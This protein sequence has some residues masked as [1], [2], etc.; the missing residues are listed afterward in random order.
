MV[1]AGQRDAR[2]R[3]EPVVIG[4][5]RSSREAGGPVIVSFRLE[6][7]DIGGECLD[8]VFAELGE[9]RHELLA[10]VPL[11]AGADLALAVEPVA[12]RALR[13]EELERGGVVG[14]GRYSDRERGEQEQGVDES[15]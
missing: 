3:R 4:S 10:I 2:V 1:T 9:R 5:D 13:L 6:R 15:P 14:A 7:A 12:R 8:L 11:L